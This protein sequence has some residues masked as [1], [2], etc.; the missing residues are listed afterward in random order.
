MQLFSHILTSSVCTAVS[1][2][3]RCQF[4]IETYV[5]AVQAAM[6]PLVASVPGGTAGQAGSGGITHKFYYQH[7]SIIFFF[8]F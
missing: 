3:K 4:T 8:F 6:L 7:M 2:L 1:E 5:Q